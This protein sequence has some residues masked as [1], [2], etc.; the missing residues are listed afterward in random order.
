M[1]CRIIREVAG[2]NPAYD[3]NPSPAKVTL[4]DGSVPT[5]D[6][7]E[8][9]VWPV[10]TLIEHPQAGIL[11]CYGVANSPPVAQAVDDEAKAFAA[12]D[13]ADR[14][15]RIEELNRQYMAADPDTA[16]GRHLKRMAIAYGLVDDAE[17]SRQY[18]AE[19]NE[20]A[21]K[22]KAKLAAIRERC[23]RDPEFAKKYE[24]EQ[25]ELRKKFEESL[26]KRN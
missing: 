18:D 24:A 22:M 26:N 2:Q 17:F 13:M 10:G 1:I 16:L 25:A 15:A 11:C 6:M 8:I 5:L 19:Q 3:N 14:P 23:A 21:E 7:P 12:A 9:I 4:P 20:L